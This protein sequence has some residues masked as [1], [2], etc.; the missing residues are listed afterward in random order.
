MIDAHTNVD[1]LERETDVYTFDEGKKT[2]K[3]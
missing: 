3:N 2:T 1:S